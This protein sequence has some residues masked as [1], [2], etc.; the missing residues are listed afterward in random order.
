V[1]VD[2]LTEIRVLPLL[3]C[4]GFPHLIVDNQSVLRDLSV[5]FEGA[6]SNFPTFYVSSDN[7]VEDVSEQN[8]IVN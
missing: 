3:N 1:F 8:N 7:V 2:F 6:G 5:H 4:Q